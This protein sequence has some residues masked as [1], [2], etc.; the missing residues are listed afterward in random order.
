M[1]L[2][3][4]EAARMANVSF[5]IHMIVNNKFETTYLNAGDFVE[6]HKEAIKVYDQ[7]YRFDASEF[8]E[9]KADIVITG[10]SAP[11]NH[12]F[13]HTSWAIVNCLPILKKGGTII[14]T[15]PCPGYH[16]WPGFALWD[17]MKPYMPPTP[18]NH[19]RVLRSFYDKSSELWAGCIWYK[20]YEAMLH[21]DVRIVTLP[22]N[23]EFARDIGLNVYDSV[24]KAYQDA[25]GK[26]G[27]AAR[28]AYV[29]YGR[30]TV[31]D[32]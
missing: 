14:F 32:V 5:G 26:H 18:E 27:A 2:D 8:K 17:L 9:Q 25:L 29:P 10:S 13:F 21:A 23:H 30:Y 19:D 12:L 7:T 24:E 3:K 16:G 11:T 20:V 15:S 22:E 1:Q 28:V 4:Y 6:A 31:L